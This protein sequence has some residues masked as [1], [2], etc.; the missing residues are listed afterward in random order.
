MPGCPKLLSSQWIWPALPPPP[1]LP[2][3]HAQ[4]SS[5]FRITPNRMQNK[6]HTPGLISQ[7]S[8]GLLIQTIKMCRL[9]QG[10]EWKL[11]SRCVSSTH[12]TGA[13]WSLGSTISP[14]D[15]HQN[16]PIQIIL[17][18][19]QCGSVWRCGGV[20][21]SAGQDIK[22]LGHYF[23]FFCSREVVTWLVWQSLFVFIAKLVQLLF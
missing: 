14:W 22:C 21:P 3:A 17:H 2:C 23:D 1:S 19:H 18:Q 8:L 7:E 16:S 5:S 6:V 10:T 20:C 11:C 9:S 12:P 4:R 15:S 13:F